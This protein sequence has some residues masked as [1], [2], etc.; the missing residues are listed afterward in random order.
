MCEAM[1]EWI[2]EE[3]ADEI[4]AAAK[5]AGENGFD[6]GFNNGLQNGERRVNTLNIKLAELG[7]TADIIKSATDSEYQQQLFKE[8]GL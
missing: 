1:R 3:Y 4:A 5:K 8:F 2:R 6:N 7:R